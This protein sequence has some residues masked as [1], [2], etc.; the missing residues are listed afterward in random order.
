[1]SIPNTY[2]S[3]TAYF[4]EG[5][6]LFHWSLVT[7]KMLFFSIRRNIIFLFATFETWYTELLLVM[8]YITQLIFL[9]VDLIV[10]VASYLK[11]RKGPEQKFTLGCII[12]RTNC[13][14]KMEVRQGKRESKYK[15]VNFSTKAQLIISYDVFSKGI[16]ITASKNSLSL[17]KEWPKIFL[18]P[19]LSR[20]SSL[21]KVHSREHKI[22][23]NHSNLLNLHLRCF[24][25]QGQ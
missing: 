6:F 7:C 3:Q 10:W 21:V 19:F 5:L 22:C 11:T 4:V 8:S 20:Q 12:Q 1:M 15:R 17:E 18:S 14:R 13:E 25:K 9:K 24:L 16:K 23:L 2:L